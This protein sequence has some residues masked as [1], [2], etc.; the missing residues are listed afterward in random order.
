M[1]TGQKLATLP[2]LPAVTQNRPRPELKRTTDATQIV[3]ARKGRI[4][5]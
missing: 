2:Q 1:S 3:A 5:E 4:T